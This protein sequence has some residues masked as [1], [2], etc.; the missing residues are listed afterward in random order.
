M[1]HT[2]RPRYITPLEVQDILDRC[3][4]AKPDCHLAHMQCIAKGINDLFKGRP[5]RITP[6]PKAEPIRVTQTPIK[7]GK[8]P[9]CNADTFNTPSGIVCTNG[10][11][12]ITPVEEC[13][14]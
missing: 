8:C 3:Y 10:H 7:N 13:S 6:Q 11:G 12:G 14:T 9:V 2:K 1:P 5:S 4:E